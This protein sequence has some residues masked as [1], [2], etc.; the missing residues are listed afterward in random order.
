MAL[1]ANFNKNDTFSDLTRGN[2][3]V[4]YLWRMHKTQKSTSLP[5]EKSILIFFASLFFS[6]CFLFLFP[7]AFFFFILAS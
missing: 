6:F 3:D 7:F 2:I 4:S 5:K 1:S